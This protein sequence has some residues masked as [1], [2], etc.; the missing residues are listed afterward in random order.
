MPSKWFGRAKKHQAV[1]IQNA[2]LGAEQ[3]ITHA[4]FRLGC[5]CLIEFGVTRN[6]V[7]AVTLFRRDAEQSDLDVGFVAGA[8]TPTTLV[9]SRM[10]KTC[11]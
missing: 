6:E 11:L 9:L 1:S 4:Q 10:M 2:R 7:E 3:T 5:M 8:S